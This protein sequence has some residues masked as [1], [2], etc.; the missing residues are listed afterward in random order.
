[1]LSC[2]SDPYKG[3]FSKPSYCYEAQLMQARIPGAFAGISTA[4]WQTMARV[5]PLSYAA[6]YYLSPTTLL[7]GL[8]G[9]VTM[10]SINKPSQVFFVTETGTDPAKG[11]AAYYI[12]PGYGMPDQRWPNGQ[13]HATGRVWCFV[14]GHAKWVKDPLFNVGGT[15]RTTAQILNDYTNMGIYTD[16]AQP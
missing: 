12:I 3:G 9:G 11:Y 7:G 8:P 10:A 4:G 5:F 2:P 1:M 13:R 6:N 14:D 16:P 15:P